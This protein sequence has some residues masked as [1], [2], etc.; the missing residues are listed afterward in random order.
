[1]RSSSSKLSVTCPLTMASRGKS[2]RSKKAT[3]P[4]RIPQVVVPQIKPRPRQV[5][6]GQASSAPPTIVE[7][8]NRLRDEY[9]DL[10]DKADAFKADVIAAKA[11]AQYINAGLAFDSCLVSLPFL[12][13][14]FR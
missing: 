8:R 10:Y 7:Q 4:V 11:K 3:A 13:R 6:Q 9:H 12:I 5:R 14:R 2:T 1:M